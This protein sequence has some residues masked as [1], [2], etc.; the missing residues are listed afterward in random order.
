MRTLAIVLASLVLATSPA[1]AGR[2]SRSSHH[3][4]HSSSHHR[5]THMSNDKGD[6]ATVRSD[7]RTTRSTINGGHGQQYGEGQ[8]HQAVRD[9]EGIGF[10]RDSPDRD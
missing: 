6:H 2:H 9:L 5:T 1:L 8:H 10:H 3:H 4:H 7:D